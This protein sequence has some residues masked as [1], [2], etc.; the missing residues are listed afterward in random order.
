MALTNTAGGP[1]VAGGTTAMLVGC[2]AA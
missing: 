1:N 2:E